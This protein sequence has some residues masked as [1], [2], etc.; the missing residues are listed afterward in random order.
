MRLSALPT[1]II[2]PMAPEVTKIKSFISVPVEG[3]DLNAAIPIT[4]KIKNIATPHKA[5]IIMPFFASFFAAVNP[6]KNVPIA[7]EREAVIVAD[8]VGKIKNDIPK[9]NKTKS[10]AITISPT[11]KPLKMGFIKLSKEVPLPPKL[12]FIKKSSK[13]ILLINNIPLKG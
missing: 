11:I 7:T 10:N 2:P 9:A 6:P 12:P 1:P 13:E 8:E 3:A 4:V 5:P